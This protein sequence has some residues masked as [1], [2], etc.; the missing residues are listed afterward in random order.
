[1]PYTDLRG[2]RYQVYPRLAIGHNRG[3]VDESYGAWHG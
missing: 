3:P 1:M 2:L